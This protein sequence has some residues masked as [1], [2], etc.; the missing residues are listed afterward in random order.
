[1]TLAGL[2]AGF[3][4][5]AL[6][7]LVVINDKRG[8][9]RCSALLFSISTTV[10][11]YVLASSLFFLVIAAQHSNDQVT[12]SMIRQEFDFGNNM[13]MAI[14]VGLT[15]ILAG[16][17]TAGWIQSKMVGFVTTVLTVT[18]VLLCLGSLASTYIIWN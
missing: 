8:I 3:S 18:V 2:L 9:V 4:F 6:I 5:S 10:F 12:K 1:M 15:A 14:I 11:I 17:A 16:T 7:A 13:E